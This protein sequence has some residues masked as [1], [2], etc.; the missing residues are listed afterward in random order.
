MNLSL[1]YY[2]G[3]GKRKNNEDS[4]SVLESGN[5]YFLVKEKKDDNGE[6]YYKPVTKD[7]ALYVTAVTKPKTD[8]KFEKAIGAYAGA[9][10][11]AGT[12]ASIEI[13][14]KVSK[15]SLDDFLAKDK[16]PVDFSSVK[17][18]ECVLPNDEI[19]K[20]VKDDVKKILKKAKSIVKFA[21]E[22]MNELYEIDDT[23]FDKFNVNG[24]D[25]E[26]S[27]NMWDAYD[28]YLTEQAKDEQESEEEYDEDEP[29]RDENEEEYDED[30]EDEEYDDDF[31]GDED[32]EEEDEEMDDLD[33]EENER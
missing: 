26:V 12:F 33:D 5:V 16:T 31:D 11:A 17:S 23:S 22:E 25:M 32:E 2:S 1:S 19:A 27:K 18:F 13:V 29:E 21:K 10:V 4:V 9:C 20:D 15:P 30:E 14:D 24:S 3:L 28:A 8:S 7:G 6:K